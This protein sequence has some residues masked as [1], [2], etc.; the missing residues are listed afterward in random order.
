MAS[1]IK[2]YSRRDGIVIELQ[3]LGESKHPIFKTDDLVKALMLDDASLFH[4]KEE[5]NLYDLSTLLRQIYKDNPEATPFKKWIGTEV[6]HPTLATLQKE[7]HSLKTSSKY[8][9]KEDRK[10]SEE[11]LDQ[12]ISHVSLLETFYAP[13]PH[14]R[15]KCILN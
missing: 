2:A 1:V 5:V 4:M 11:T 15:S 14:A 9:S 3:V 7:I 10:K 8:L 13:V 6:V 12:Y